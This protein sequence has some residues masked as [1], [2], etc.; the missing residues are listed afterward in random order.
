[1]HDRSGRLVESKVW[2]RSVAEKYVAFL[3]GINLG[4]RRVKND[5]LLQIFTALGYGEVKVLIASGN[6]VFTADDADEAR[7][8]AT[9]ERALQGGLG[10]TVDTMLRTADEIQAMLKAEPFKGIE[11]TKA[12]RLYVTLLAEK[13]RSSMPLPYASE[14]G[15]FRILSRTDREVYSAL[16]VADGGRTVDLMAVLEREY[17]K[18]ATTRNWNTIVKA[19]AL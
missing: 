8:T 14:D 17:G 9:V 2:W 16:T 6:V 3:R 1:M 11:V 18:R 7:V 19:A 12:T 5:Q 4:K 15:N 10:F 13:T